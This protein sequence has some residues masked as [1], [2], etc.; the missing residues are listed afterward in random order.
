MIQ[1]LTN[2]EFKI[3][4]EAGRAISNAGRN[5]T[6]QQVK[7]LVDQGCIRP[8]FTWLADNGDNRELFSDVIGSLNTFIEIG[9][10]G[11]MATGQSNV[12]EQQLNA[13]FGEFKACFDESMTGRFCF[14][15]DDDHV[16]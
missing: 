1:L 12:F 14:V 10:H 4:N 16:E 3:R 11:S 9:R 5:G 7:G 2:A 15:Y 6:C 13:L 8:L